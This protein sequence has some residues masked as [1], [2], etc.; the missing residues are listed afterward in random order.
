[1]NF[2]AHSWWSRRLLL[3]FER[4]G[5]RLPPAPS[6]PPLAQPQL[7]LELGSIR[8]SFQEEQAVGCRIEVEPF[9]DL[10]WEESLQRLAEADLAAAAT[11]SVGKLPTQ[12][13]ELFRPSGRKLIPDRAQE[14]RFECSCR[15]KFEP[16]VCPHLA[17]TL[18]EY[19]RKL[20]REPW[21]LFLLRG[22][23]EEEVELSLLQYWEAGTARQGKAPQSETSK[24]N[25][26]TLAWSDPD[27]FWQG[28]CPDRPNP[29]GNYGTQEITI[30][31]FGFPDLEV[32]Q[33]AWTYLLE[34]IYQ[35]V[36]EGALRTGQPGT[37]PS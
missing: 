27:V 26:E 14:V 12:I 23:S 28:E 5:L 6:S 18:M 20:D 16:F 1:M 31:R 7:Y 4:L 3:S 32:D 9:H 29:D 22:R 8:A 35:A 10:E 24:V 33:E 34:Q 11:L 19:A 13:E 36:S 25:S 2:T 15:A 17:W 21:L 37:Q 30:E